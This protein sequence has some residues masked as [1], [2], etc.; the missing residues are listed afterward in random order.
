M[1]LYDSVHNRIIHDSQ[2]T[3]ATQQSTDSW[4]NNMWYIHHTYSGV[5]LRLEM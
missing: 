5:L 1:H 3:E 4:I 2:K